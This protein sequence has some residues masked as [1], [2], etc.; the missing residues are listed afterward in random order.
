MEHEIL[1]AKAMQLHKD[2]FHKDA[3][4]LL[5]ANLDREKFSNFVFENHP[6]CLTHADVGQIF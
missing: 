4:D 5:V 3:H 2:R 1:I 6:I